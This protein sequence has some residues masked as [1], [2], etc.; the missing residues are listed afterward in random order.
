MR[1]LAGRKNVIVDGAVGI[2]KS[3]L[4]REVTLPFRGRIAGFYTEEVARDGERHGFILRTFAGEECLFA[5]RD[6][7]EGPRISKY[8]VDLSAFERVGVAA[9]ERASAGSG[10]VVID[11]IGSMEVLSERFRA[12]LFQCLSGPARTLATIRQKSQPFESEIRRLADTER[13][14]VTRENF[15]ELKESLRAWLAGSLAA[16]HGDMRL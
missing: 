1:T 11:E 12:A 3:T 10:V 9:I 6:F 8:R 15:A 4:I 7:K 14:T 13:L 5:S 16:E 2:G